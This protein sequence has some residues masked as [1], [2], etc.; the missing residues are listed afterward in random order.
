M[1]I[2]Q[3][4]QTTDGVTALCPAITKEDRNE[5]ESVWHTVCASAAISSIQIHTVKMYDEHGF[6]ILVKFFEHHQEPT[7]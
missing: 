3:E 4:I 6:D 2:I 7:A 5:A 1:Y